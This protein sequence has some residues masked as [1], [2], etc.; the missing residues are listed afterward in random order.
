M[1]AND[2]APGKVDSFLDPA[3]GKKANVALARARYDY[4]PEQSVGVIFTDREFLSSHSRVTGAD[5]N[6]RLS[7]TQRL[8][9]WFVLTDRE[10]LTG[11]KKKG[12]MYEF[13]TTKAGRHFGYFVAHHALAPDLASDLGFIRR[14]NFIETIGR[15]S[16]KWW[17]ETWI[18][19]YWPEVNH[20]R[21]YDFDATLLNTDSGIN[22]NIQFA[23][24]INA[25]A[26]YHRLMERYRNID[27]DK[28]RVTVSG[29]INASRR[30][31]F[32][33]KLDQGDE[34]RFVVNP[35]LGHNRIYSA[36]SII[37]PFSR[38]QATI[39]LDTT[40]FTDPRTGSP[41][42]FNIKILRVL[43][44]YQFTPRLLVR[45]IV[46]RNTFNRTL[47]NNV[48]MTYRVNSGTAFYLG[49]DDHFA[50]GS[51]INPTY[52]D[53]TAFART[54]RAIF[55]KLQYLFRSGGN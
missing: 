40:D 51:T 14:T 9:T 54:N 18:V 46:Q 32:T 29:T 44:T 7:P 47:D 1:F 23:R 28:N 30:V 12:W 17:P 2:E 52:F 21:I 34:I 10:D 43:T 39:N 11:A 6:F 49:Y 37:R 24:N 50:E 48:L 3:Y 38:L 42:A 8:T 53:P 35:F 5:A 16:Y 26:T 25:Q 36:S 15:T 33:G 55:T 19:N 31:S 13:N 41:Q 27:F 22:F 45:S 20:S 4:G